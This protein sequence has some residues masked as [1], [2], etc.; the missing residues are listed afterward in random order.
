M[1]AKLLKA[2]NIRQHS[3]WPCKHGHDNI[4]T[5]WVVNFLY[6]AAMI[7]HLC[8][9]LHMNYYLSHPQYHTSLSNYLIVFQCTK[10]HFT[11]SLK[12][13]ACHL[14]WSLAN[15]TWRSWRSS[16]LCFFVTISACLRR[17][18]TDNCHGRKC[19]LQQGQC[20]YLTDPKHLNPPYSSPRRWHW[21][22]TQECILMPMTF[23]TPSSSASSF[24]YKNSI[25]S[26]RNSLRFTEWRNFCLK[27]TCFSW[28]ILTVWNR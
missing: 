14:K 23:L 27:P 15:I 10:M 24:P 21:T 13:L 22:F 7:A 3:I 12:L 19:Q 6:W 16:I 11:V 18:L 17:T 8:Y 25:P 9:P 28:Y 5:N 1:V 20:T 4:W 2:D 26:N